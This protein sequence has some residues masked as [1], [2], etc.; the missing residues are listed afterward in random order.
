VPVTVT[1]ERRGDTERWTRQFGPSRFSSTL[2][3]A[4]PGAVF[5]RFGPFSFRLRLGAD[6]TGLTMPVAAGRFL[7]LP[8]PRALLPRSDTREYVADGRF[9]FDVRLSLPVV[10]LLVHYKGSLTSTRPPLITTRDL[11][12][13]L[14]RKPQIR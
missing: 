13:S 6:A 4:G 3:L 11:P 9:H 5:E 7:G 1:M 14:P 10:G 12:Y 8:L 2:R